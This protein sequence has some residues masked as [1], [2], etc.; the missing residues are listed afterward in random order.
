VIGDTGPYQN[1]DG[2][3]W[4]PRTVPYLEARHIARSGSYDDGRD[5]LVYVGKSDADLLGFVRAC[6]CEEQCYGGPVTEEYGEPE[7]DPACRVPAWHF[8]LE[9]RW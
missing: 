7:P 9:E 4:V 1:D 8:R 6:Q 3:V 5:R 2:D